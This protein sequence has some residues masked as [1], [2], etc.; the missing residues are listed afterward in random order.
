M[1]KAQFD[2]PTCGTWVCSRCGF[3]RGKANRYGKQH[4]PYCGGTEGKM[5]NVVHRRLALTE[6]HKNF[7]MLNNQE[8]FYPLL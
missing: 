7:A 6:E 4:C 8:P 3:R 1:T 5:L 2:C